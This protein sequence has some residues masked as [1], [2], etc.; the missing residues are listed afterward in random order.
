MPKRK[1]APAAA[2]GRK[3]TKP[4]TSA[5]S[6][7]AVTKQAPPL[8]TPT[9]S[10]TSSKPPAAPSDPREVLLSSSSSLFEYLERLPPRT[11]RSIYSLPA[12]RGPTVAAA[13]LRSS[14]VTDMARQCALRLVACGG[15]FKV[16]LIV[17]GWIHRHGRSDAFLALRRLEGMGILEPTLGLATRS[18][19]GSSGEGDD[20]YDDEYD[21]DGEEDVTTERKR[22]KLMGKNATLTIEFRE[23]MK[24]YLST[25]S[26]SPWPVISRETI[27]A[28]GK[29]L[30]PAEVTKGEGKKEK[31]SRDPPTRQE[32]DNYTQSS[33]DSVLH[34]LVGS[35]ERE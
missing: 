30:S 8:R 15:S 17:E 3:R 29:A 32:L 25:S 12:P 31:P 7:P 34:F 4:A 19:R 5:K 6:S 27:D 35:G 23:A 21:S 22:E 24:L 16:G 18:S 28:H 13:V 20:D 11:L 10:N 26:S 33:W 1:G 14:C 9:T 2:S